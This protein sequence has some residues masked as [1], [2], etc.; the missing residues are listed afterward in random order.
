MTSIRPRKTLPAA[1][2]SGFSAVVPPLLVPRLGGT[3]VNDDCVAAMRAAGSGPAIPRFDLIFADPPYYMRLPPEKTLRRTNGSEVRSVKDHAW[4]HFESVQD[5]LDFSKN[6]LTAARALM[7]DKSSLLVSGTYHNIYLLGGMMM[8]MGFWVINDIVWNKTNPVPNFAGRRLTNAHETILWVV[9]DEKCRP[10]FDYWRLKRANNDVQMR[11]VWTFPV[12]P[13]AE[14]LRDADGHAVHPTQ[15]PL[16]LLERIVA[17]TVP[18]GGCVLD[19]FL[20]SGTTGVAADRAGVAWSGIERDP[21]MAIVA[22][23]RVHDQV[24]LARESD[25]PA[26]I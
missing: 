24:A 1:A 14:R 5:Y 18:P 20:G 8:Q 3:I 16:A 11:D 17:M 9:R 19:P 21:A 23:Q 22:R 13:R 7:H 25:E 12:C 15:K 26:T 6:W 4:D 10:F 2:T